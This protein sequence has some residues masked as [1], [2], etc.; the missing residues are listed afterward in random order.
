[1]INT[2]LVLYVLMSSIMTW[3]TLSV[4][5]IYPIFIFNVTLKFAKF[6]KKFLYTRNIILIM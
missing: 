2:S 5:K 6:I 1:M 3:V 4:T